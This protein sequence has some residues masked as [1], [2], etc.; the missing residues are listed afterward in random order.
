M[1][2]RLCPWNIIRSH[3]DPNGLPPSMCRSPRH[4]RL[5]YTPHQ[6]STRH[7]VM[8][9]QCNLLRWR[10]NHSIR[11]T[12]VSYSLQ[13]DWSTSERR[14]SS[15]RNFVR[16]PGGALHTRTS[17]KQTPNR[18]DLAKNLVP[19][20]MACRQYKATKNSPTHGRIRT[21]L[22]CVPGARF[23]RSESPFLDE[24]SQLYRDTRPTN[25]SHHP[26]RYPTRS[27]KM[28]AGGRGKHPRTSV[29]TRKRPHPH[30]LR[31]R[32]LHG[33]GSTFVVFSR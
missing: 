33:M 9:R 23:I 18:K 5:P 20:H 21:A 4:R 30:Y 3:S 13:N 10:N 27:L 26:G 7:S 17:S 2:H 15:L 24:I 14:Q 29:H 16:F 1:V 8:C 12:N 22:V 31:R 28:D 19:Q 25:P 32:E 11:S 6:P